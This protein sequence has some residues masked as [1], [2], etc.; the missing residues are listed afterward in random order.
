MILEIS[1][2]LNLFD[3]FDLSSNE[4]SE[5][6]GIALANFLD[7]LDFVQMIIALEKDLVLKKPLH[8]FELLLFIYVI[9][10]Q[11]YNLLISY[12]LSSHHL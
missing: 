7:D 9:P 5:D 10:F 6:E 3:S 4:T 1:C 11:I 8:K 12:N 2:D